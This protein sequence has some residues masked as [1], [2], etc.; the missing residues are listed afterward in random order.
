MKKRPLL[1]IT[2]SLIIASIVVF[3]TNDSE[4]QYTPRYSNNLVH[5]F[6]GAAEYYNALR[7]NPET[8]VIDVEAYRSIEKA[9]KAYRAEKSGSSLGLEWTETGPDNIGG[10]TR[11][12]LAIDNNTLFAGS[13][14]GGLFKTS[15]KGNTWQRVISFSENYVITSMAR[16]GNG[17]IYVATGS[18][19]ET[20]GHNQRILG[21]GLFVSTDDGD[22]WD[23]AKFA[24]GD[25]I[26]PDIVGSTNPSNRDY[27]IIDDIEADPSEDN[28]LWVAS[29]EGLQV[30]IDG[31]GLFDQADG[32]PS[33]SSC[34]CVAVSA[35]GMT[36]AASMGSSNL[37]LSTNGGDSFE[38]RTGNDDNELPSNLS[39][40][41]LDI[42]KDDK[43][44]IYGI[45]AVSGKFDGVY[46]ST[47]GGDSFEKTWPGGVPEVDIDP[48]GQGN[49]DLAIA[50]APDSPG[51]I[52]TGALDVWTGGVYS[53]PEQRSQ[54]ISV[55]DPASSPDPGNPFGLTQVH[56]DIH[57]F[58]FTED[59]TMYVG[60]DGGIFRSEDGGNTFVSCNRF[61]NST[62]YY[63]LA[64]SSDDKV[65]GGTQD[66]SAL[67]I[68][69]DRSTVEEARTVWSGDGFDAEISNLDTE[70]NTIFFTSQFNTIIRSND[71]G[72]VVKMW[73]PNNDMAGSP[74]P[75]HSQIRLWEDGDTDTP[76]LVDFV[77]NTEETLPAGTEVEVTS[78]ANAYTFTATLAD[79]LESNDTTQ[80]N[81]RATSLF[82]A[83]YE[84]SGGVWV[85]REATDFT[86]AIQWGKVIDNL[87]T[88]PFG[89]NKVYSQEFSKDGKYLWI[90]TEAGRLYRVSG[91]ENAWTAAELD[92]NSPDFALVV[93][94]FNVGGG[95]IISDIS[96]DPND[97]DHVVF[98]KAGFGGDGKVRES[99]NATSANPSFS[100][101]WFQTEEMEGLPAYACIIEASDPNTIIVGTEFGIYATDNGGDDWTAENADPLGPV[102]VYD[103]RQQWRDPATVENAGYIYVGTYGRGVFRS[104][105]Y[106]KNLYE[107]SAGDSDQGLVND[108]VI[109][110]NPMS[111]TGFL[112][113]NST[114]SG[115]V[116]MEIFS[117]N[118]QKVKSINFSMDE[119]ANRIQFDVNDLNIGTYIIQLKK[120]DK[121]TTDKFVIIR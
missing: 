42:S 51:I 24:N 34:E 13:V 60:T 113:F 69:R 104:T 59:E 94:I 25:P 112:S 66:N 72:L 103:I 77:N 2:F 46:S 105:T 32:L 76:Y 83:G 49:Y 100:D 64:F 1:F 96:V 114:I 75:F 35:D 58:E 79:D 81:D 15:N 121:V 23:Y 45:I 110:P 8:G 31:Q 38:N 44:F 65:L 50:V 26:K 87:G 3:K 115:N 120:E 117:I 71:A 111:E 89:N 62:Q 14:S 33:N 12:I 73:M 6:E 40:L 4:K 39:R 21:G 109:L 48:N 97:P 93:D 43:D 56:V 91:F 84:G 74:A 108:L 55:Y 54:Y 70:G 95:E 30:Y 17:Y 29:N 90:G 28:K 67:Y 53:Q 98:T 82:S 99:T 101:I 7:A 11:A 118:G 61:Y 92:L 22:T 102:K 85:T 78:N 88:S 16:T 52:F 106:E 41:E 10:R 5:G 9:E 57:T 18:S 36:I 80:F 20:G 63:G 116:D 107:A 27:A 37:F 47:N 19:H 119:G 86:S 68:T